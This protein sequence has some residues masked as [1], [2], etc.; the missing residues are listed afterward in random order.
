MQAAIAVARDAQQNGGVAIG[1]V[2]VHTKTGSVIASGGSVVGVTK[3]PTAHAEINCIRAASKQLTTDDL[4]D[5]TLYSTLEPCSMCLGA[6]AWARIPQVYFGAYRKDVDSSLF[7]T[8]D[9]T[10]ESRAAHMNLRE[11]T[12]MQITGGIL[13]QECATL[14]ASYHDHAHHAK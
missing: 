5:C 2:L 9:I 10:D 14:L 12:T 3:D 6:A 7:D 13:E 1:A 4:F 11:D 8:D